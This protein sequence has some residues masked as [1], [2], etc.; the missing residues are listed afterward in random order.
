MHA[1]PPGGKA[2][3]RW[4]R[5]SPPFPQQ[6]ELALFPPAL[7][8]ALSP[9]VFYVAVR[10]RLMMAFPFAPW[11]MGPRAGPRGEFLV[12]LCLLTEVVNLVYRK[13]LL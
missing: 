13:G 11:H 8:C 3:E 9:S 1:F 2:G 7:I 5:D 10:E 4:L 12:T 6:T